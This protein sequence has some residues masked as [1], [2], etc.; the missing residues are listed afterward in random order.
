GGGAQGVRGGVTGHL[1]TLS[2][3]SEHRQELVGGGRRRARSGHDDRARQAGSLGEH[4]EVRQLLGDR[5]DEEV[6]LV[7]PDEL[8]G[9]TIVGGFARGGD[10]VDALEA[11]DGSGREVHADGAHVGPP[12]ELGPQGSP[13]RACCTGD[14]DRATLPHRPK[15]RRGSATRRTTTT[16]CWLRSATGTMSLTTSRFTGGP[17][18]RRRRRGRRAAR[19]TTGE[20]GTTVL[21]TG[22]RRRR[23]NSSPGI[24]QAHVPSG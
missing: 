9:R 2:V 10:G 22:R 21:T 8:E 7:P 3:E 12:G 23:S 5:R 13:R 17:A 1:D 11:G 4:G 16:R 24:S 6:G 19:T 20:L 14:D 18:R 15:V